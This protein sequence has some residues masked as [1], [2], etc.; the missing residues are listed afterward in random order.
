MLITGTL[1]IILEKTYNINHL[2]IVLQFTV[3]RSFCKTSN[4]KV[5]LIGYAFL[6]LSKNIRL[7]ISKVVLLNSRLQHSVTLLHPYRLRGKNAEKRHVQYYIF[8]TIHSTNIA[9]IDNNYNK[10]TIN[11]FLVSIQFT[12]SP[13]SNFRYIEQI[14]HYRSISRHIY[15]FLQIYG[16]QYIRIQCVYRVYSYIVHRNGCV[17]LFKIENFAFPSAIYEVH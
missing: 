1:K 8:K 16:V 7:E 10:L 3:E 9:S 14:P 15:I 11:T 13:Y 12:M 6:P 17:E 5:P 4:L 2:A